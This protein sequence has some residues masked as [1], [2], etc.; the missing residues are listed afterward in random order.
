MKIKTF[1]EKTKEEIDRLVNEFESNH[2]V[3][4]TQTH[5]TVLNTGV[6]LYTYVVFYEDQQ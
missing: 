3:R 1:E 4:A 5:L 2:R 6:K